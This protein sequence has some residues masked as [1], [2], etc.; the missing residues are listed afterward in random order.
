MVDATEGH[1]G[2]V[3]VKL[4][5]TANFTACTDPYFSS[6]PFDTDVA[7][8]KI[9]AIGSRNAVDTVEG[10]IEITGSVERPYF[11][12]VATNDFID[13]SHSLADV[14]GLYGGNVSKC[15]IAVSPN[16]NMTVYLHEVKFSSYGL[17]L[18]AQEVTTEKCDFTCNNVSTS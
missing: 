5:T 13:G 3:R 15:T 8:E 1:E 16:S 6:S 12:A 17:S 4:E 9:Y 2:Y 7:M 11:E 14:C 10:V 18:S